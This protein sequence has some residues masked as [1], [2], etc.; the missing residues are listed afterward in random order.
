M[1]QRPDKTQA[2]K[3][4]RF[5]GLGIGMVLPRLSTNLMA[6]LM[7]TVAAEPYKGHA[8]LPVSRNRCNSKSTTCFPSPKRCNCCVLPRSRPATSISRRPA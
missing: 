1:T 2:A 6:G 3:D 7:E 5:P 8:D 4:G